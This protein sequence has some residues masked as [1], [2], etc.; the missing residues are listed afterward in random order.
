MEAIEIE[1]PA[2]LHMGFIDP[3]GSGSRRFGS[4]G[5]ALDGL[6]TRVRLSRAGTVA[7]AYSVAADQARPELLRAARYLETLRCAFDFADPLSLEILDAIPPHAGLGS[8]TQLALAIGFA[9]TRLSGRH[10]SVA[11]LAALTDRGARS[12]IGVGA[13]EQGGFVVDG[14]RGADTTVPPV[15]ARQAFPAA[16]RIILLFDGSFCG[17]HG[18]AEVSAFRK[19]PPFPSQKADHLARLTL[20]QVLPAL[21][22]A[23]YEGFAPAL[24]EIQAANGD[25]FA[26][27]Q[28]G[29]FTSPDVSRWLRWFGERGARALGQSSWGPTGFVITATAEEA[30]RLLAEAKSVRQENDPVRFRSLAARNAGARIN[31]FDTPLHASAALNS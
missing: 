8:G 20:T 30:R 11:Q 10:L 22:E 19:L 24:S 17:L 27:A 15:I 31:E 9:M 12:G 5:L 29:R 25:H 18:D 28:G 2:R 3:S 13:F 21:A 1:S 7:E 16:W 4:L 14:G 6:S 23:D 26:P